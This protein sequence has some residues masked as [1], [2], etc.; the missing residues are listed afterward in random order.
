M[1]YWDTSALLKLYVAE[2]DSAHFATVAA[3]EDS[4]A[5]STIATSEML[6]AL[7]RKENAGGLKNGGAHS[8]LRRFQRDVDDGRIIAIPYGSDIVTEIEKVVKSVLNRPRP[9]LV[10]TLDAIHV[11]SA[12]VGG[13]KMF[14]ATDERLRKV[15]ALV[16]LKLI[17]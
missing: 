16:N 7:Y 1:T 15:A 5:T 12:L 3:Q 17:P 9:A 11:A 14:V 6:C 8:T 13:A 10:R 2:P 4:L